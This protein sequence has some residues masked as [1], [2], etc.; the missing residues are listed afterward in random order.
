MLLSSTPIPTT[1]DYILYIVCLYDDDSV[2]L[3]NLDGLG[4]LSPIVVLS[5]PIGVVM[6]RVFILYSIA[7]DGEWS[8]ATR[9]LSVGLRPACA[10]TGLRP[11]SAVPIVAPYVNI[12]LYEDIIEWLPP[13]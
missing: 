5:S 3:P 1:T 4:R 9:P 7:C 11:R 13:T 12:V 6:L 8:P 10:H 2:R